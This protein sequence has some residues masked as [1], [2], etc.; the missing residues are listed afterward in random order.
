[1]AVPDR[2]NEHEVRLLEGG[3]A[4]DD[5]GTVSFVNGF[6]FRGVKRFYTVTNHRAGF[7]R[8]WHAHRHEA[9]SIVQRP[10][11][12]RPLGR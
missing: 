11:L 10:G 7:V 6:D 3:L 2:N 12:F 8:A 1:M 9:G 5:R 4:V